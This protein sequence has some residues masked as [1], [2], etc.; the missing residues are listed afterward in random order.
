MSVWPCQSLLPVITP[1]E[2]LKEPFCGC[3]Q[4]KHLWNTLLSPH[5]NN[6][7]LFPWPH[8]HLPFQDHDLHFG[9]S[10]CSK[11]YS[12]NQC[13][14]QQKKELCIEYDQ[15]ERFWNNSYSSKH[16]PYGEMTCEK[17]KLCS[18]SFLSSPYIMPWS[19]RL[20]S[21]MGHPQVWACYFVMMNSRPAVYIRRYDKNWC[22][23]L[24]SV[25]LISSSNI[26]CRI[27]GFN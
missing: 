6:P 25:L 2:F 12:A 15:E 11:I 14:T 5:S 27:A 22:W 3:C 26:C 23:K 16:F 18:V 20:I 1:S 4:H 13:T 19:Y 21:L 17:S 24:A 7:Q 8:F 9:K 10:F